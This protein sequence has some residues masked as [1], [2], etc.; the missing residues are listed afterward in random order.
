L[1]TERESVKASYADRAMQLLHQAVAKGWRHP[2]IIKEDP[3]LQP[4]QGREDF[5]KLIANLQAKEKE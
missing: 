1:P 2:N 5:Q 4:L 3:M